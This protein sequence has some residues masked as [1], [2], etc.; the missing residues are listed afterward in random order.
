M[1]HCPS[2][3][4]INNK[5]KSVNTVYTGCQ[6]PPF[7]EGYDLLECLDCHLWY[8]S[9][10]PKPSEL[11]DYY[12]KVKTNNSPW[13]NENRYPHEKK[14]DKILTET[15]CPANILDV[16]CFTGKL[17]SIHQNHNLFGI[18]PSKEASQIAR[19]D[20][21]INIIG[22]ELTEKL[23][24][25][26]A[27]FFNIITIV[28]VFEHLTDPTGYLNRLIEMLADEGRLIIVSGRTDSRVMNLIGPTYWYFH[29]DSHLV[30]LNKKYLEKLYSNCTTLQYSAVR[31]FD[32]SVQTALKEIIWS[33][34]WTFLCPNNNNRRWNLPSTLTKYFGRFTSPLTLT[35]ARDHAF[36][37]LTKKKLK[38]GTDE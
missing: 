6:E 9:P 26:Y 5:R 22:E 3:K 38:K 23:V 19:S 27:N 20:Y 1:T 16:G 21:N 11:I 30:F 35:F 15:K 2:C 24:N 31:H 28:D 12:K 10:M 8:K 4:S 34:V 14:I 7:T 37:I 33:F 13:V 25:E 29:I 36:V 18:E 32:S 17:L